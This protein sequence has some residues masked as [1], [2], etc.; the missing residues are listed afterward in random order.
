MKFLPLIVKINNLVSRTELLEKVQSY[1]ALEKSF[2]EFNIFEINR[3]EDKKSIGIKEL[4]SISEWIFTKVDGIKT[5]IINSADSI[6]SEGQNSLL[7]ILEEP[8]E[9]SIMILVVNNLDN[10]LETIRS[11]CDVLYIGDLKSNTT[12]EIKSFIQSS[13]SNREKFL[14][15]L[16]GFENTA[17]F[18]EELTIYLFKNYSNSGII[19]KVKDSYK[20]FKNGAQSKIVLDYINLLLNQI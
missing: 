9:D 16:D 3:E 7:K 4:K 12:D 17:K 10:L 14:E 11:R 13:Y 20:S 6:T 8:S 19:E 18:L 15:K 5:L 1:Y 2:N